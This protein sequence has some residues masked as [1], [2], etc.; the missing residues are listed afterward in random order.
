MVNKIWLALILIGFS[1]AAAKGEIGTVTQAA[2][3]GA[4]TGVTVC[5]GLISVLVFWLGI[6][7]LAEDS[8]LVKAISRLLGPVVAI[9]SRT[10]RK[11]IQPW[12]TFCPT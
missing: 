6:M 4:A 12:A 3:D 2:F 7:R 9:C 5:F 10:C 11:T 8:G 1:F